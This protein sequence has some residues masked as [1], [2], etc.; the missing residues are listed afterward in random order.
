M[1]HQPVSPLQALVPSLIRGVRNAGLLVGTYGMPMPNMLN[2]GPDSAV[3]ALFRDGVF[4]F[5][6]H[7]I[8]I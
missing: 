6:G 5:N 3:D 4:D 1:I 7:S 2:S 8:R